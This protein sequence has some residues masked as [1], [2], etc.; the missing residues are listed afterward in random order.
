MSGKSD[1]SLEGS[2]TLLPILDAIVERGGADAG[3][4]EVVLG[5]AH[6]G[7][8]EC[9]G[10]YHR[11]AVCRGVSRVFR[12]IFCLTRWDGDGDVK[13]HLGFSADRT[14]AR[15]NKIHPVA[16]AQSEATWRR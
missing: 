10:E 3:L 8:P 6:R 9:T 15:G 13:Y 5:M 7:R 16:V 2:E 1:F 12:M 11:Q 14:S 4:R